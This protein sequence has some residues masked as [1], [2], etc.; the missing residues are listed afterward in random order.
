MRWHKWV[1]LIAGSTGSDLCEE[2]GAQ[3]AG[4]LLKG[5]TDDLRQRLRQNEKRLSLAP[6]LLQ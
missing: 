4:K 5:I 6:V 2:P 1:V 3:L